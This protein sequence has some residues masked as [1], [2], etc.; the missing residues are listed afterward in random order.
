MV[1]DHLVCFDKVLEMVLNSSLDVILPPKLIKPSPKK[2]TPKLTP[3]EGGDRKRKNKKR[4]SDK[5]RGERVIKNA[6]FITEFHMKDDEVWKRNFTGKCTRDHPKWDN[7]TFMC[8][9]WYNHVE[10]F[11]DCNNKASHIGACAVPS[12]KHNKFKTFLGK[13]RQ[14]NT[15]PHLA[16]ILR[17]GSC[18]ARQ[19]EKPPEPP[20]CRAHGNNLYRQ[21]RKFIRIMWIHR[22]CEFTYY[23]KSYQWIHILYE[24][25]GT[26]KGFWFL[27]WAHQL[28]FL[29]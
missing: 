24:S 23:M 19:D 28:S 27:P 13:V 10:C 9:H 17:S 2:P 16:W 14:E 29:G 3:M 1:N 5:V 4:K 15:S 11:C 26:H 6:A 22:L 7:N 18:D 21:W 25:Y 12:T 8:T 20:P